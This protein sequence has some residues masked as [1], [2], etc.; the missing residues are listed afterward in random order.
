MKKSK[1]IAALAL[2]AS[3]SLGALAGCAGGELED[4]PEALADG[5]TMTAATDDVGRSFA[6]VSDYEQGKYVGIFYFLW[7]GSDQSPIKDVSNNYEK[8]GTVMSELLAREAAGGTQEMNA[9]HYWGQPLYGYYNA[10][11]EWVIRKHIEL[12]IHAGLDFIA[13]DTS[14]GRIYDVQ[15]YAFLDLL[16]EYYEQGF[17]VP[18]VMFLTSVDPTTS[19]TSVEQIYNT[20][21]DPEMYPEYE[22]LWFRGTQNKPWIIGSTT[23]NSLIDSSFYFKL[24]QWPNAAIESA[25]FPWMD[26]NYPQDIYT[27][28]QVG[29]IM[30]VSVSQHVGISATSKPLADFSDSGLFAP[31]N[32]AELKKNGFD[33]DA[34]YMDLVYNAN[35]GRGYD[36]T[37]GKNSR[38]RA[39]AEG[40]N[41][42]QQW[43][44]VFKNEADSDDGNDVDLVFVT[45]WNEWI[46]QKQPNSSVL[47]DDYCHFVDTFNMEFSRD[48]EMNAEYLDNYYLSLIR[49]VREYKGEGSGRTFAESEEPLDSL[50][51][52]L[53]GWNAENVA[54]FRDF[55]GE[56]IARSALDTSGQN[57]LENDT[58]RNDITEVRVAAD[59]E[60]VYLL[61]RTAE[62]VTA[63]EEGDERWMNVYLGAEGASGGWMGM[64]YVLNRAPENG[65]TSLHRIDGS[66]F[67]LVGTCESSVEGNIMRIR[68]PR[69]AIGLPVGQ[70]LGIKVADNLQK[71]LDVAEFYV[72][73]DAAPIGRLRYVYKVTE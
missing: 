54:V 65:K 11:D 12:F 20:F 55:T 38:E 43:D 60:N 16:L 36:H 71:D 69:S 22:P 41:F 44:T 70:S 49:N 23:G 68:V 47:G 31:E 14:N 50:M 62:D 5:F 29:N 48:I 64:Q 4:R 35:W 9:F 27:D 34:N 32:R 57:V 39:L 28:P 73:G 33:F 30:S 46:A 56:T 66:G 8:N 67:T 61:I 37:E 59:K 40:T 15:A 19:R 7:N 24:P 63:H 58:G 72:N 13:F 26:W 53:G 17:N 42:E 10:D 21:Y 52:G 18:K 6:P 45:G 25:R 3:M 2:A 51:D 1:K